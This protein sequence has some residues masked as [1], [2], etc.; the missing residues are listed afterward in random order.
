MVKTPLIRGRKGMQT[1]APTRLELNNSDLDESVVLYAQ[2]TPID[3]NAAG[4]VSSV[5]TVQV[6]P[7]PGPGGLLPTSDGRG[8]RMTDITAFISRM[9]RQHPAARV[10]KDHH[11][12]PTSPTFRG[13][14]AAGGWLSNYRM[15]EFGGV[16]VDMQ[17]GDEMRESLRKKEYRYVSPAYKIKPNGE[18]VGL[19]SLALTN[20]PN[21]PLEAPT[22]HAA[23]RREAALAARE[24][25]LDRR[26][27]ESARNA[28]DR[29]IQTNSI[30][31]HQRDYF[32][33]TIEQHAEGIDAWLDA[34]EMFLNTTGTAAATPPVANFA[35]PRGYELPSGER[36]ALHNRISEYSR[37]HAISYRDAMAQ[38]PGEM[39]SCAPFPVGVDLNAKAGYEQV[40]ARI[41][42]V[43]TKAQQTRGDGLMA[44]AQRTAEIAEEFAAAGR[45]PKAFAAI[46]A[47]KEVLHAIDMLNKGDS[48]HAEHWLN[49]PPPTPE[50][51]GATFAEI[52]MLGWSIDPDTG[53]WVAP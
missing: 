25:V 32:L 41:E 52:N 19:S 11:S 40:K 14:T 33:G 13:S 22:L 53:E 17:L 7:P 12:E 23:Q 26:V 47:T 4:A 5:V 49:W 29:A 45:W 50:T 34:F 36:V 37:A 24:A 16:D 30:A 48:R 1:T 10:D 42:H 39:V 15:N 28:V 51:V 8:Q 2:M 9:T 21:L 38:L 27:M 43:L 35:A 6:V 46:S 18:I 20:T 3:E 31:P 44:R